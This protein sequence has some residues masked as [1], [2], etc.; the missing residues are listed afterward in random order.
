MGK[1]FR[2]HYHCSVCAT[3]YSK[4]Q[5]DQAIA[6]VKVNRL[7]AGGEHLIDHAITTKTTGAPS[8]HPYSEQDLVDDNPRWLNRGKRDSQ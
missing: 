8:V 3:W 2:A 1:R 4:W 6:R 7:I 5:R